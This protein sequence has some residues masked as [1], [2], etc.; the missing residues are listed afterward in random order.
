MAQFDLKKATVYFE[1]GYSG[2]GGGAINNVSKAGAVN[3]AAGYPIGTTTLAVKTF[4]SPALVIGSNITI[5][6]NSYRLI[7]QVAT[8][9]VTTSIT[10]SPGLVAAV[11]DADPITAGGFGKGATVLTV[12]GFTGVIS[13]AAV[14]IT[15]AGDPTQYTVISQTAT[16]GNTTQITI[17]TPGL[18][19][20]AADNAAIAVGPH[21][22]EVN[23]GEGNM[24]YTEKRNMQYT[25]SRGKLDTVREGD[26]VP[27]EVRLDFTWEFLRAAN[28]DTVPTIE[29]VLKHRGLASTWLS[30]STDPCEPYAIN[31]RLLYNPEC[32]NIDQEQITLSDFRWEDLAHDAKAGTVSVTG[33][34]NITEADVVRLAAPIAA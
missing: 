32:S 3:N 2:A 30:S 16:L 20:A 31:I 13:T 23:L 15:I 4:T 19:A 29:D 11:A 18:V 24:T 8:L 5:G 21:S 12:D 26:E 17:D 28:M 14:S 6:A 9:G 1:D 7:N 33:K 10:I 27:L 34:C 22:L 25:L